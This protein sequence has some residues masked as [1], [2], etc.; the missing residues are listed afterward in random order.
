VGFVARVTD[1][2]SADY[3][4]P[5]AR[6]AVFDNDGTLWTEQPIYAELAF[7]LDRVRALAPAHPEWAHQMPYRAAIEG[8][9]RALDA[10]GSDGIRTLIGATHGGMTTARFE[11]LVREWIATA[12]NPRFDRRYTELAFVPMRELLSYLEAN[13]FRTYIVSG[14]GVGFM[15]AWA[16]DVYGIPPERVLGTRMRMR[17]E[18]GEGGP[19][20]RRLP[21]IAFVNDGPNKPIRIHDAIGRR[22]ILAAGNSDGD[23]QMLQWTAAGEGPTLELLVHHTDARR[24][25]AYDRDSHLGE[26]DRA[27]D[28]AEAERWVVVDMARDWETV[29]EDAR[30]E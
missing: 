27:L 3:V 11:S 13:G 22:P 21:K 28:V 5:R 8:D 15:R 7:V 2:R 25:V 18:M 14:G 19:A 1:P 16:E 24:E 6:V 29:F 26:L 20:L 12:R 10:A 17:W 23:L 30:S 4:P 9:L